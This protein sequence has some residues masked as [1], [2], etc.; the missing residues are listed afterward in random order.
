[1][2][3]DI[4]TLHR[5]EER[6]V[7]QEIGFEQGELPWVLGLKIEKWLAFLFVS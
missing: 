2:V 6:A 7:T 3:D 5:L 1:V 4:A